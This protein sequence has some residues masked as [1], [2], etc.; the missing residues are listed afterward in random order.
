MQIFSK[1]YVASLCVA[2]LACEGIE[3]AEED[4]DPV[5]TSAA[6][7][8]GMNLQGM[9][10]QG[11][12]LQ[13]MNLQ[14]MNLQGFQLGNATLSGV[15]LQN[16]RVER[17]ELV[18]ERNGSTL[19]GPALTGALLRAVARDPDGSSPTA[20][21]VTYRIDKVRR[22]PSQYDPTNTGSTYLYTLEQWVPESSA[23]KP[24][25]PPDADGRRAAIPVAAIWDEHGDRIPSSS[26]FTLACTTGVIAKCYRWGYRPWVTGYGD[27]AAMHWTC[28][29]LA[30]ADYCGNGIPHTQDGTWINIWD[31][32]PAPGPIQ[33]RG[34]PPPTMVFEA[35]WNTGGAVCLGHTRWLRHGAAIAAMCPHRLIRPGLGPLVCNSLD[36]ALLIEPSTKMFNESYLQ[37]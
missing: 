4:D 21:L 34:T 8:E 32:L 25:C 35:G 17:G 6:E 37:P 16:L 15:A 33:H 13:G 24:A 36:E 31:T 2:V 19:R 23:W 11:M 5:E 7:Q 1:A 29:R 26:L 12:N 20:V 9:N 14:G 3:I 10:L 28:T 27:L 18:A 30:R 22:E